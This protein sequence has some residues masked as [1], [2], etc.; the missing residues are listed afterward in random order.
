MRIQ[1][2]SFLAEVPIDVLHVHGRKKYLL[3]PQQKILQS[4]C[5]NGFGRFNLEI[6]CL[7]R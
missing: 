4:C 2:K 7:R 1:S 6:L 5:Y 3:K